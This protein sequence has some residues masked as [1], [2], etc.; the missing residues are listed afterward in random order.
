MGGSVFRI[1]AIPAVMFLGLIAGCASDNPASDPQPAPEPT[2]EI[3][4][5][6]D[7]LIEEGSHDTQVYLRFATVVDVDFFHGL[8]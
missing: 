2:F 5:E 7:P 1:N 6:L 3:D 8:Q 4:T